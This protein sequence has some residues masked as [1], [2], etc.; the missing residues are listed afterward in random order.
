MTEI[1][2]GLVEALVLARKGSKA[3][4]GKNMMKLGTAPLICYSIA[5]GLLCKGIENTYF[6]SDSE[7]MMA[8]ADSMG[9]KVPFKRPFDISGDNATDLDVIKHFLDWYFK[10]NGFLPEYLVQLRPTLPF[11][12]I[13]W[14]DDCISLAQLNNFGC[15]RTITDPDQTPYK[16]WTR[17]S[18]GTIKPFVQ[19]TG[20]NDAFNLP[21]QHLPKVYY[22][23]GQIDVIKSSMVIDEDTLTGSNVYGYQTGIE[24]NVDIDA[25]KDFEKAEENLDFLCDP[26]IKKHLL[27]LQGL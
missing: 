20:T 12:K 27:G 7:E 4:P 14:I 18:D 5:A 8:I 11:R 17:D 9:A 25:K 19:I 21:R 10:D 15:V 13:S 3:L 23:T 1:K 6:S 2:I 26:I 22:H 16:M 24:Y